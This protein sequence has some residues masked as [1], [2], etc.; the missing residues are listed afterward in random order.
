MACGDIVTLAPDLSRVDQDSDWDSIRK[1]SGGRSSKRTPRNLILHASS[2]ES[3]LPSFLYFPLECL[4]HSL[5]YSLPHGLFLSLSTI[6]GS[7]ITVHLKKLGKLEL[8]ARTRSVVTAFFLRY[9][10]KAQRTKSRNI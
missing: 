7:S 8:S 1:T 9:L 5:R 10:Y 6:K 3:L 4:P 2:S